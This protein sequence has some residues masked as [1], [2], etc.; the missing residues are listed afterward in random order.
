MKSDRDFPSENCVLS[1]NRA[2]GCSFPKCPD[3]L[4]MERDAKRQ[5]DPP[6]WIEDEYGYN[7]CS[8]CGFEFD[9]AEYTE[10]VCPHCGKR[11]ELPEE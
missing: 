8:A 10:P 7:H 11:M 1:D 9:E 3:Y 5:S 2:N 6:R 4:M